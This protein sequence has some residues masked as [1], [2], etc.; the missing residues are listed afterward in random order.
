VQERDIKNV[1]VPLR[2]CNCSLFGFLWEHFTH[3]SWFSFFAN[4]SPAISSNFMSR[5]LFL[6]VYLPWG[7]SHAGCCLCW[8]CVVGVTG[9]TGRVLPLV[10]LSPIHYTC[11]LQSFETFPLSSQSRIGTDHTCH[12]SGRSCD[13]VAFMSVFF[14][15]ASRLALWIFGT[16]NSRTFDLTSEEWTARAN[17][18]VSWINPLCLFL[19]TSLRLWN[20][21]NK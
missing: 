13:L 1:N 15:S 3:K 19:I 18:K 21:E 16:E 9:C 10:L 12:V 8:V 14:S 7:I 6:E 20:E 17:D 4:F 5:N 2:F 11:L